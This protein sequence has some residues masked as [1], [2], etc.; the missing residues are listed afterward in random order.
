MMRENNNLQMPLAPSWGKHE[1]A[2]VLAKISEVLDEHPELNERAAADVRGKR[3]SN[4]GRKGM[5]GEQLLRIGLVYMMFELTYEEL[6]FHLEDSSA[7]RKFSRV[8]FGKRVKVSTLKNNLRRVTA[9]TWEAVN[10]ALVN[11]A[12]ERGIEMG[13]MTRTD[14]TV[15]ETNIHAP[16]D[17]SLLWD[18]VRVITRILK[19]LRERF[20]SENWRFHDHTRQAKKFA[21]RIDFPEKKA[22]SRKKNRE[23]LYPKLIRTTEKVLEYGEDA[24][25]RIENVGATG[26]QDIAFLAA[27]ESELREFVLSTKR[28]LDQ[29]RRR[30]L[31]GE[32]VP[33]SDKLVSIFE[34]HTDIII[35]K[36]RETLF[37]HKICLT[38]G[39]SSMMLDVV[40]EDGNPA[41]S[42]MVERTIKRQVD[43]FGRPP[44]QASFDGGFASKA[45]LVIAKDAGVKDVVFHKKCGLEIDD[46]AK[47]PWVFRKLRRFRAGI[48]GCISTLK[49]AFKLGRCTWRRKHRFHAYVW[50]SIV[51]FNAVILGRR[52]LANA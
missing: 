39:K 31:K 48:E 28:V 26:V 42:K 9:Q 11:T 12:C 22:G 2:R 18:C 35:K 19:R 5:T 8:P 32:R 14:C 25:T 10:L 7:I 45:N 41:D 37:G 13:R 27:T 17:S 38:G 33:A 24:L 51:S 16:T 23:K 46:M 34:T 49:R 29:T 44:R 6:A 43:V 1:R 47:S 4:R 30:V 20:P 52:L 36:N 50:A 21:Y 15:V 40:I 3:K